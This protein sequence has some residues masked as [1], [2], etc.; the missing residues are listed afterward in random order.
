MKHYKK[1]L[2]NWAFNFHPRTFCTP[3]LWF[4]YIEQYNFNYETLKEEPP[5]PELDIA[6]TI[7]WITLNYTVK[8]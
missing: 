5:K 2:G 3:H 6:L 8:L 1:Q 7:F 4:N